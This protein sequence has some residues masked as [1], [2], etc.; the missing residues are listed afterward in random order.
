MNA[1]QVN[2]DISYNRKSHFFDAVV[3]A[4]CAASGKGHKVVFSATSEAIARHA[5]FLALPTACAN[6]EAIIN[7][8]AEFSGC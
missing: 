6:L 3:I 1:V 8:D 7:G 5:A 4:S 2:I